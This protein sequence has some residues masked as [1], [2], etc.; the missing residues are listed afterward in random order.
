MGPLS[1]SRLWA[2]TR[3]GL[4]LKIAKFGDTIYERPQI[5]ATDRQ[6]RDISFGGI[7]SVKSTASR[8]LTVLLEQTVNGPFVRGPVTRRTETLGAVAA[9]VR[10]NLEMHRVLVA[11][12]L[13]F[14]YPLVANLTPSKRLIL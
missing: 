10:F 12:H 4:G 1:S 3:E 14:R 5:K 11:L 13:V 8:F 9:L 2:K 6:A 7:K